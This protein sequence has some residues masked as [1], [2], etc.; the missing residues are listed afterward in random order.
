MLR[1]S[2][3]CKKWAGGTKV[4]RRLYRPGGTVGAEKVTF[5]LGGEGRSVQPEKVDIPIGRYSFPASKSR[6]DGAQLK[7]RV[8]GQPNQCQF[9]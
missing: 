9:Y 8:M 4:D 7:K 1:P 2:S 5:G 3:L 6:R